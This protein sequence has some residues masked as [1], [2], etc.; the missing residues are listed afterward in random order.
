MAVLKVS[1]FSKSFGINTVFDQVSFEIRSGERIGLVGAN[2]AGKST[3]LK[4]MTG[5]E[6]ADKGSVKSSAGTSIGY[7]R[8]DFNY[9]HD[10]LR[11][12]MEEAWEDVLSCQ[13]HLGELT[14]AMAEQKGNAEALVE[15][16]GKTEERFSLLGGYEY[17]AM[18]RKILSGLGFSDTDWDRSIQSFSG[19]QKVRI[20]LAICFGQTA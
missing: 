8:Q 4:C 2:G 16:Y 12:E 19:G 13:R 1:G 6:E 11:G 9:N 17:E 5:R 7:L 14:Q 3:L 18:T 15:E 20:N 10:T